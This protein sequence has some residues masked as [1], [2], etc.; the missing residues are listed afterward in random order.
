MTDEPCL[1]VR[2]ELRRVAAMNAS[3][4]THGAMAQALV[5]LAEDLRTDAIAALAL[6]ADYARAIIEHNGDSGKDVVA[7]AMGRKGG[8]ARAAAMAPERR[9]EIA[10]AAAAKRWG[11]G[12]AT[13]TEEGEQLP[14][15]TRQQA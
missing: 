8:L 9:T 2:L 11:R 5:I 14:P 12:L 10:K 1:S 6:E 7:S 3:I 4:Q 15:I 13:P